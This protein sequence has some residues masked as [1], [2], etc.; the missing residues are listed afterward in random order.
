MAVIYGWTYAEF[1]ANV[2]W[3]KGG[4]TEYDFWENYWAIQADA[5]IFSGTG[6]HITDANEIIEL[7]TIIN[8]MMMLQNTYL[9]ADHNETPL[10]SGFYM[11]PGPPQFDGEPNDNNGEGSGDYIILNKLREKHNPKFARAD[12]IR[13]R[14]DPGNIYFQQ[15]RLYY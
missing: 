8:K 6:T 9:K 7:A 3:E 5:Y 15:D 1:H 13:I 10:Q 12:S 14:V 4:A 2:G 11:N